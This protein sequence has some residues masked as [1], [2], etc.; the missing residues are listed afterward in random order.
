MGKPNLLRGQSMETANKAADSVLYGRIYLQATM[1]SAREIYI[2]I[3]FLGVAILL[4][5]L[6]YHFTSPF[7]KRFDDKFWK[8]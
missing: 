2:W 5:I 8:A 4:S 7:T 3:T 1:F 6:M